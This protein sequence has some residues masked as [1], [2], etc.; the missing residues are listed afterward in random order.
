M[1][2]DSPATDGT[3]KEKG[4]YPSNERSEAQQLKRVLI[5]LAMRK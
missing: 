3:K 2:K 1:Y 5:A 4:I